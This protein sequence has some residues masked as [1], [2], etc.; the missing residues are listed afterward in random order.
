MENRK[1]KILA[2]G[3]LHGDTDLIKK[4]AERTEKENVDLVVLAGDLTLAETSTY[5]LIGPFLKAKKEILLIP[6]NHESVETTDALS[7]LYSPWTKNIHGNSF[8]KNNIGIFGAGGADLG[9]QTFSE[10]ETY[11]LLKRGHEKI[12]D[13][14][15]KIMVTH[16]HTSGSVAEFSGSR[17]N[18]GIRKAIKAFKPTVL[19]N[20]HIHE[21]EGMNEQIENTKVLHVGKNGKIFYL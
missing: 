1:T 21:A 3:D 8:I 20:A 15:K 7:Q 17:G 12:K 2:V 14:E 16:M 18:E 11:N 6:G 13:L 19:I 4:L 10:R 9:I 5:N